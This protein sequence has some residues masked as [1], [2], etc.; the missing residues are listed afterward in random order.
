M[1]TVDWAGTLA[2]VITY[3]VAGDDRLAA[4][5]PAATFV[6]VVVTVLRYPS[7]GILINTLMLAITLILW[8][9]LSARLQPELSYAVLTPHGGVWL[10]VMLAFTLVLRDLPPDSARLERESSSQHPASATMTSILSARELDILQFLARRDLRT[11]ENVGERA[12]PIISGRTV[13]SH[14]RRMSG[15]SAFAV[16]VGPWSERLARAASWNH[17]R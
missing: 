8:L 14:L 16:A 10:V 1:T 12:P 6:S 2:V 9:V 17:R 5:A 15:N 13:A 4:I 11:Y 3:C 7:T